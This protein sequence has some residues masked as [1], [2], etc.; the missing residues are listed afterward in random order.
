MPDPFLIPFLPQAEPRF[1]R[2][3]AAERALKGWVERLAADSAGAGGPLRVWVPQC[4][5]GEDA[6]SAAIYLIE[7][8]GGR[9]R[10]ADLRVIGTDADPAS[11]RAA[12][13]G[14][15]PRAAARGASPRRIERFFVKE[16]AGLRVRRLVREACSFARWDA[17]RGPSAR[18][19]T[20]ASAP[21]WDGAT[22]RRRRSG[23]E[24]LTGEVAHE[25]RAPMAVIQCSAET[26]RRGVRQPRVRSE[27]LRA[28]Q[29]QTARMGRLV[30]RLVDSPSGAERAP[31]PC[32]IPLGGLLRDTAAAFAPLARRRGVSIRIDIPED[33]TA[34]ADPSDLPHVFGNLLNN[35]VKFNRRD[36]KIRI[37]GR[38]EGGEAI[39]TV[40]DTGSG[41]PPEDLDRVFDRFYRSPRTR[42]IEGTGLG[43]AIVRGIVKANGGRVWAENVPGG[44]TA[45]HVRLPLAGTGSAA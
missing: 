34:L 35:A 4:S 15:Y 8:L 5:T 9:W 31:A 42:H 29:S 30:D 12:R 2:D 20:A 6:Y 38:A 39:V 25:L 16:G 11:L 36:G 26:L 13:E 32:P 3:P 40:Q 18:S 41:I 10:E 23:R 28:I 1:F 24:A 22:E 21:H 17:A 44:G 19:F 43:L 27:F 45:F 37:R 33:L 7:A 14:L